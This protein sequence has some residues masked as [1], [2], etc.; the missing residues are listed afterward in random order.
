[1][2]KHYHNQLADAQTSSQRGQFALPP[3]QW[4]GG[5]GESPVPPKK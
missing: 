2:P 1:M 3:G 4:L 5:T